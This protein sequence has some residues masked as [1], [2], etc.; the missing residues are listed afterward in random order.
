MGNDY[1][2]ELAIT[3]TS[4]D[5]LVVD[6]NKSAFGGPNYPMMSMSFTVST[7]GTVMMQRHTS[8][9]IQGGGPYK[10]SDEKF[11]ELGPL[12]ADLPDDHS[13]LPPKGRRL[14]V[15][16][17]TPSGIV[18]RVYDK[19]NLPEGVLEMLRVVGADTWPIFP[20]PDY[21]P[22]GRWDEWLAAQAREKMSEIGMG[23]S[24]S[25]P[26]AI[27]PDGKLKAIESNPDQCFDSI[28]H[29]E[30]L[31]DAKEKP[32]S[33][34]YDTVLRIEDA[35]NGDII[36]DFREP[37]S[38]RRLICMY[39]AQFTPD[40]RNLLVLSSIPDIRI[41]DTSTWQLL[42][43]L[44]AVPDGAVAYY[45]SPD[46]KRG[47]V[48][49]PSGEVRLIETDTGR[50]LAQIDSGDELQSVSYSPNGAQVAVVTV[51]HDS[52]GSYEYHLRIW[53]T[54]T[55]EM[56]HEL[57]PLEATPHDGFGKPVWWPDGKYLL[58][59]TREGH[60][61]GA[62]VIGIWNVE[63]GRYRGGLAG[64]NVLDAPNTQFLLKGTIFFK[65]CGYNGLLIWDVEKDI[66]KI[67]DFEKSLPN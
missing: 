16:A 62:S 51:G 61:G 60:Y 37:M 42:D 20:F 25:R 63:S 28:V 26:L 32:Y 35:K 24:D 19:A 31:K 67:A 36:H 18:A 49:F 66:K 59:P 22:D 41:Y 40:G 1:P 34:T 45:P 17:V 12:M 54:A 65:T 3:F 64:C 27:S 33:V 2:L 9:A 7:K 23:E 39:A 52:D 8:M 5:E 29:V 13:R 44:P 15:Q 55:G 43:R 11:K 21:Q 38:G 48:A 30:Q 53:D 14:V 50:K 47:V 57:R 56:V 46:W 58:S 10:L 6:A 4:G